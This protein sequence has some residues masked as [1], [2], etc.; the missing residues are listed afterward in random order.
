VSDRAVVLLAAAVWAGAWNPHPIGRWIG[1]LLVAGALLARRP[2]L[3]VLGAAVLASALSMA[4]WSGLRPVERQ[5]VRGVA[6]LV[7]DPDDVHGAVRVDV[8]LGGR[9]YEAWART[10]ALRTAMAGERFALAGRLRPAPPRARRWLVPRHVAG[11]LDVVDARRVDG[12][13]VAGRAA[14]RVRRTLARGAAPLPTEERAVLLGVV[15]GDD[16]EQSAELTDAFRASGLSHLLVVSGENVAFVLALAGP[17]LRR[18]GLRARLLATLAVLVFF[19]LLTRWE[20]SVLR[21]EAM[22]ALACTVATMGRPT[23]RLRL[24]AL[25]VAGLVLIDPLL[26]KAVGFQ[27]SVGATVGIVLLAERMRRRLPE[28]VAVT[29]AAQIGVA[30]VALPLFGGLPLASLPANVLA[31]PVAAPLT[32]WGLTAG[33]LAEALPWLHVPTRLMAWWL[34]TVA[35]WAASLPLGQVHARQAVLLAVVWWLGSRKWSWRSD[36]T[37]STSPPGPS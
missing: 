3:L 21:A 35:R 15:L 37:A 14:N 31:I 5:T 20:P 6:T 23:S 22:A 2:V 34:I 12:G 19:G 11:R 10:S 36:R 24:L 25:A 17:L 29:L 7:S 13:S 26:V 16:R 18:L 8:R 33:L 1:V 4:A 9:R 30:P 27:L 28:V 32:A